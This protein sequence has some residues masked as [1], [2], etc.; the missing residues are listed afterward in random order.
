MLSELELNGRL[1]R[2]GRSPFLFGVLGLI[3]AFI[4]FQGIS[5]VVTLIIL[6]MSGVNMV[7]LV[8]PE[9]LTQTLSDNASSLLIAN[10]IGQVFGLLIPALLFTRL[11]TRNWTAFLR[12]RRVDVKL[13]GLS[14]IALL[15]LI[16]VVQWFGVLS[17]QLPWP[18]WIRSFEKSQ[19][20]LIE[21]I[22]TQD[23]SLFFTISVLAITPAICEEVLFRGYFQRQSERSFGIVWGIVLSGVVFG[24]YHMRLTQAIPLSMLGV[25]MAYLTWRTKSIFPAMLVHLA[26]NSFAAILGKVASKEGSTIDIETFEM[27]LTIVLPA[28]II[29]VGVL[30]VLHKLAISIESQQLNQSVVS[31]HDRS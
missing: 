26:N 22:L 19:M 16:P 1:E 10:T 7:E 12:I 23:F 21:Q 28:A 25:F 15:A 24:L 3:L 2:Y 11:H 6:A 27:P 4:L 14:V 20:D 8:D 29:L 17:D 13:L 31:A 5:L 9:T 30:I 18:E